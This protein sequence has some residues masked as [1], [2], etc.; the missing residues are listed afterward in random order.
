MK[1]CIMLL[2]MSALVLSL[3]TGCLRDNASVVNTDDGRTKDVKT[4]STE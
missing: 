2:I 3:L 4:E 1:K